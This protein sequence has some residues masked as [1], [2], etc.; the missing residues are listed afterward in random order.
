MTGTD[1]Y[2][3]FS[4]GYHGSHTGLEIN[5]IPR[6]GHLHAWCRCC[7]YTCTNRST[8]IDQ[9]HPDVITRWENSGHNDMSRLQ[10]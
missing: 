7:N 9:G 4:K 8:C 10:L 5:P 2:N 3:N 1:I 6:H